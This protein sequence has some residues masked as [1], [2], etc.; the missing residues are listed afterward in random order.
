MLFSVF[1]LAQALTSGFLNFFFAFFHLVFRLSVSAPFY[2]TLYPDLIPFQE[3]NF[4]IGLF[5]IATAISDNQDVFNFMYTDVVAST[6]GNVTA[7]SHVRAYTHGGWL[8]YFVSQFIVAAVCV[9]INSVR[10]GLAGPIAHSIVVQGL[11]TMYMLS[12][13]SIR[14]ALLESYGFIWCLGFFILVFIVSSLLPRTSK[15][16]EQ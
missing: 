3:F 6:Q 15:G 16:T 11:L 5:G 1:A 7:A 13:T 12:Q 8:P 4:G 10:N 9:F 14:G 2:F